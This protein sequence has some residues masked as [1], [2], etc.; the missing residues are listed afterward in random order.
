MVSGDCGLIFIHVVC[1]VC[2]IFFVVV[3]FPLFYYGIVG[4][5]ETVIFRYTLQIYS[6]SD[7]RKVVIPFG[8]ALNKNCLLDPHHRQGGLSLMVL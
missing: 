8:L 3:V 5:G 2:V 7:W 6:R 1:F 4:R